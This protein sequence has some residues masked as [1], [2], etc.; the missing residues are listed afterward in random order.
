MDITIKMVFRQFCFL[1]SCQ[2]GAGGGFCENPLL[3]SPLVGGETFTQFQSNR[4]RLPGH[5]QSH[6]Q[7]YRPNF[8]WWHAVLARKTKD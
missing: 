5:P 4:G 1:P 2:G 7:S 3:V 8:P 6:L